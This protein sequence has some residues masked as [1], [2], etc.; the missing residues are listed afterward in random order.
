MEVGWR[1]VSDSRWDAATETLAHDAARH[2][3]AAY[4]AGASDVVP[5]DENIANAVLAALADTG[6]LVPT[7]LRLTEHVRARTLKLA[8][9]QLLADAA[10]HRE[11]WCDGRDA[12]AWDKGFVRGKEHAAHTIANSID[13][14]ESDD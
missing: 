8:A 14:G 10:T 3:T 2:V 9:R 4:A 12:S 6:Q 11:K 13:R 1:G 7:G 5:S